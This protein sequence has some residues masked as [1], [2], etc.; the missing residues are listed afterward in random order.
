MSLAALDGGGNL[1]IREIK[2]R[3]DPDSSPVQVFAVDKRLCPGE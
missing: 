2:V 3:N 1:I